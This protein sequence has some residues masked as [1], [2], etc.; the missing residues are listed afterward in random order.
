[1]VQKF[2][3]I[4]T[5][6]G[7]AR[8]KSA[9]QRNF[10]AQFWIPPTM[11]HP[12]MTLLHTAL[13]GKLCCDLAVSRLYLDPIAVGEPFFFGVSRMNKNAGHRAALSQFSNIALPGLEKRIFSKNVF[14]GS[15][16]FR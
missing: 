10:A 11:R 13:N 8:Q 12:Q 9:G 4:R 7:I 3:I 15:L 1:M 16:C 5:Q 14:N 6:D 2:I